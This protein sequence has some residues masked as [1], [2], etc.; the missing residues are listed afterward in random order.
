[1]QPRRP[2]PAVAGLQ[3]RSLRFQLAGEAKS[4][5]ADPQ[6]SRQGAGHAPSGR[7]QRHQVSS[8]RQRL[9]GHRLTKERSERR[10]KIL[11]G[12]WNEYF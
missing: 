2:N 1:M 10:L 7:G 9:H 11:T 12:H 5:Q 8:R 6:Q 3:S 4:H